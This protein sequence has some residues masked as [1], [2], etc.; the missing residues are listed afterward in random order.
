M[1]F[2]RWCA[3]IG[4]ALCTL[5]VLA[6]APG[7]M[8]AYSSAF[9]SYRPYQD[10][11]LADWRGVNDTVRDAASKSAARENHGSSAPRPLAEPPKSQTSAPAPRADDSPSMHH[12]HD[13]ARKGA[14]Q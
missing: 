14:K 5:P 1:T 12:G 11:E 10:P 8:R 9:A 7:P 2:I 6:Q 3:G 13:H 4:A